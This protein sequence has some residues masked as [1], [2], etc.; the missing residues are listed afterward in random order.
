MTSVKSLVYTPS[1]EDQKTHHVHRPV[2]RP[3]VDT[4]LD[5]F[6]TGTGIFVSATDTGSMPDNP[7]SDGDGVDDG[8]EFWDSGFPDTL[9]KSCCRPFRE[10]TRLFTTI[11]FGTWN[12]CEVTAPTDRSPEMGRIVLFTTFSH[13][14]CAPAVQSQFTA[15]QFPAGL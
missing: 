10:L 11:P 3:H 2:H 14:V 4:L 9:L 7:D 1:H 15:F 6:E 5:G 12:T 13:F 8:D